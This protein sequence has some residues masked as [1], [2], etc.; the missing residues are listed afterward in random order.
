MLAAG[1]AGL[2][3]GTKSGQQ[4]TGVKGREESANGSARGTAPGRQWLYPIED[5]EAH[6]ESRDRRVAGAFEEYRRAAMSGRLLRGEGPLEAGFRSIHE[7]DVF[8]L[9]AGDEPGVVGRGVVREVIGRPEPR[10]RFRIDRRISRLLAQDPV[11]AALVRKS[12]VRP[13]NGPVS[14]LDHAALSHGFEW[15]LDQLDDRDR[16]RLAPLGVPSLRRVIA[17]RPTLL[18]DP[19]L[20]GAVRML[21]SF[22]FAVGARIEGSTS[23][24]L[25]GFDE[26]QLVIVGLIK[27]G[28]GAVPEPAVLRTFASVAW[29]GWSLVDGSSS[30][31]ELHQWFVFQRPP[32]VQLV[33]FLEDSA[34]SVSW[35]Q[36]GKVE[37][38]PRTRRRWRDPEAL[39]RPLASEEAARTPPTSSISFR[40]QGVPE[41][42]VKTFT[43][44]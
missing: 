25:L 6:F 31:A 3:I 44:L 7:G 8:W 40:R 36:G 28:R 18:A 37:L 38:G 22:D 27:G 15:W 30:P 26:H 19:S 9:Y 35:V 33:R 39:T 29:R 34:H 5:R 41:V 16:R 2:A 20:A 21:R 17:R 12:L 4:G 43:D 32:H 24:C 23:A 42:K 10:V 13:L 14:L 11:P 1:A